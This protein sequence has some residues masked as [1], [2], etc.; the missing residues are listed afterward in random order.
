VSNGSGVPSS[1]LPG[2]GQGGLNCS[3]CQIADGPAG[4]GHHSGHDAEDGSRHESGSGEVA[5]AENQRSNGC[6]EQDERHSE[7]LGMGQDDVAKKPAGG[8][9]P[10]PFYPGSIEP[11]TLTE[12]V[13]RAENRADD[14][15]DSDGEL[16]D[17]L[18][19]RHGLCRFTIPCLELRVSELI[20]AHLPEPPARRSGTGACVS[21]EDVYSRKEGNG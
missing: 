10:G 4:T 13:H 17:E 19:G 7:A 16:G 21:P 2:Q 9:V 15:E 11:V 6:F 3:K 14:V 18:Q 20:E 12:R 5:L 1:L 8:L